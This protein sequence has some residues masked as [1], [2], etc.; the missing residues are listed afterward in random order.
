[1][2][3]TEETDKQIEIWK[4]KRVRGHG[5]AA[6]LLQVDCCSSRRRRMM[7]VQAGQALQAN[8]P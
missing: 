1:M 4:V 7:Q 3:S 2:A 6:K 5:L 8:A